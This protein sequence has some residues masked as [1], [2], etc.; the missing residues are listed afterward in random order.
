MTDPNAP[1]QPRLGE[2]P[3]VTIEVSPEGLATYRTGIERLGRP[4][5]PPEARSELL[6]LL[7]RA[8]VTHDI[9]DTYRS[10]P[11]VRVRVHDRRLELDL[12][13]ELEVW[14]ATANSLARYYC[15]F[16]RARARRR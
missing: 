12:E 2:L 1:K 7:A 4:L 10:K 11:V 6:D 14:A 3:G 16:A 9:D 5:D 8:R 15:Y 13:A